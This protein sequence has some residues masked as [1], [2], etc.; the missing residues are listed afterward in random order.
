[1]EWLTD[2]WLWI[3]LGIGFVWLFSSGR[4]GCGMGSTHEHVESK[5][6]AEERA[7]PPRTGCH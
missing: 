5:K 3:L 1:M 7:T 4:M 6:E 2:N